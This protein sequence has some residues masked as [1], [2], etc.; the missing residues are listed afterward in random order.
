[1]TSLAPGVSP[2]S[3]GCT[4][5]D[6]YTISQRL[7]CNVTLVTSG[8]SASKRQKAQLEP[9]QNPNAT[10]AFRI[11]PAPVYAAK[12]VS[13]LIDLSSPRRY[14]DRVVYDSTPF[15]SQPGRQPI[16]T[17][18]QNEVFNSDSISLGSRYFSAPNSTSQ[19]GSL[20]ATDDNDGWQEFFTL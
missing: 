14:S 11:P 12:E 7:Q 13:G 8:V 2:F 10:N 5:R 6:M 17:D 1:M 4:T 15:S 19:T 20:E 3:T 16:F 18:N 9:V